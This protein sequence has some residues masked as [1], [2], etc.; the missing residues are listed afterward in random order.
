MVVIVTVEL[1]C[2][3][4]ALSFADVKIGKRFMFIIFPTMV[5]VLLA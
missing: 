2:I 5:C 3:V 1:P 4:V